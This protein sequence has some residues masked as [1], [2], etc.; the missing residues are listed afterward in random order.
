MNV[1]DP[2]ARL[3]GHLDRCV[4]PPL[5]YRVLRIAAGIVQRHTL[6]SKGAFE[7]GWP[8]LRAEHTKRQLLKLR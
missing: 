8:K 1:A 7:S 4:T 6:K 3:K 2:L 5:N